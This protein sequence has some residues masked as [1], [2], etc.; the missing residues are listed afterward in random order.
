MT[1]EEIHEE[2]AA[3]ERSLLARLQDFEKQTGCA[4]TEICIR[5]T[6][7]TTILSTQNETR[8]TA[9]RLQVEVE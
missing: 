2:K 3:L 6:D 4:V 9:V 7:I 8:A 5:R 1:V